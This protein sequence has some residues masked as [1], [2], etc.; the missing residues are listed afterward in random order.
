MKSTYT[1]RVLQ[2]VLS[3]VDFISLS[4]SLILRLGYTSHTHTH[5]S[6]TKNHIFRFR[7]CHAKD[8]IRD[9]KSVLCCN[10]SALSFYICY[11]THYTHVSCFTRFNRHV[12]N[13]NKKYTENLALIRVT[14]DLYF[15]NCVSFNLQIDKTHLITDSLLELITSSKNYLLCK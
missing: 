10:A 1:V 5:T 12:Q 9:K 15:L 13:A 7:I 3:G 14:R 6:L 8:I 2:F 4:L 11:S